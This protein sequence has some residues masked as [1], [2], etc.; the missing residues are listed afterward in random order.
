M[1]QI[2]DRWPILARNAFDGNS[3]Y[4]NNFDHDHVTS[5]QKIDHIIFAG[6]GGSGI[7]ADIFAAILSMT[8]MHV[9]IVKGYHLPKT[10]DSNTLV[11]AT[12]ISGNTAETLD[13]LYSAAE[14]KCKLAAFS[15]GGKMMEFCNKNNIMHSNIE[16][17]HSPRASFCI[18]LYSMLKILEPVLPV[19]KQDIL[20]SLNNLESQ[21]KIIASSNLTFDDNPAISLAKW[22]RGIPLIY[23]PLG[24]QASAIRF[25]NSLQENAKIHTIIEDVIEACHNGIVSWERRSIVQ[26]ILIQGYDDHIRTKER[27]SILKKYFEEN[28]IEYKEVKS[29]KHSNIISKIINLIYLLDY[30]SIYKAILD[31]IDPSPVKSINYIKKN[32]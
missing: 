30:T 31:G 15:S 10:V 6:M 17:I 32:L 22:I 14:Q 24:L 25:K 8:D 23:Y 1:Y 20:E 18:F 13:V 5:D 2:Y 7:L 16:Y 9:G 28:D 3:I 4:E 19:K 26:P 12:S 27:W 11:V 21:N 29:I